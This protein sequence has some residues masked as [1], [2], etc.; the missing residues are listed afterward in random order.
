MLACVNGVKIQSQVSPDENV[1]TVNRINLI[2]VSPNGH[3]VSLQSTVAFSAR[4][5]P[6]RLKDNMFISVVEKVRLVFQFIVCHHADGHLLVRGL[7]WYLPLLPSHRM[8][9]PLQSTCSFSSRVE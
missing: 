7:I 6:G 2:D 4:S 8:K 1:G 9:L 5:S 3:P